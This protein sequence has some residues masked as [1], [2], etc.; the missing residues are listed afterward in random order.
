MANKSVKYILAVL[1]FIWT[2]GSASYSQTRDRRGTINDDNYNEMGMPL[3]ESERMLREMQD[4][5]GQDGD[6]TRKPPKVRKPLE[7]FYFDD[8][9]R[10]EKIF[11]WNVS[12]DN[13][14]ITRVPVDTL[15]AN[16]WIDYKFMREDVGDASLGNLGGGTIPLNYFRRP[17]P[18]NFSFLRSWYSYIMTPGKLKYYNTKTAYTRIAYSMSGQRKIEES[19][20][21]A[22]LA[23][24]ISPSSSF[25][26]E[27]NADGTKG[28]YHRQKALDRYFSAAF[29]HTG[30]RYA[31]HA[32]YIFNTADVKDNGGIV[33]DRDVTDTVFP[34]PDNVPVHLA[35]A[36]MLYKGNTFFVTQSY[37]IPLRKQ[38]EDELTIQEI[39]SIFIGQSAEYTKFRRT[40]TDSGSDDMA[41]WQNHYID[42]ATT[43][44]SINQSLL[45]LKFFAQIQPYNREGILG[46]ITGGIG[47]ELNNYYYYVPRN[48]QPG[49]GGGNRSEN[50]T[51]LYGAVNGRVSKYAAWDASLKYYMLGY[52]SQDFDIN[53]HLQLNAFMR[54]EPLTF[55]ATVRFSLRIP[56]FWAQNYF[57]NHYAWSNSFSK[58][59]LTHVSAKFTV[60]SWGLELGGDYAMTTD[61]IYYDLWSTPKQ[62]GS[63]L[64][65][66]GVYLRKDFRV[67][68]FHLNHRVLMQWSSDQTVAPVPFVSAYASYSVQ[69]NIKNVL[70]LA[71]GVDARYNTEYYGFAYNPAIGQFYN[72]RE[73]EIGGYPYLDGF[74]SGKWKRMRLLI[75]AQHFN[76][77][78]FGGQNYFMVLHRPANRMM[79]KFGMSWSFYD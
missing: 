15:L 22:I 61:K 7:S 34:Q 74:I 45:D 5:N 25:A 31:I 9:T 36:G 62:H 38:K 46:I 33:D 18:S 67:G 3:T 14:D 76:S 23:H 71:I 30:K 57:S 37:G 40:F 64:N 29:A 2:A 79:L 21:N 50:T 65:V 58:E 52:R 39:P 78:L 13:N 19:M 10:R 56:D 59:A 16:F 1:L 43:K 20:F 17:D 11:A 51:Y 12:L 73:Q 63:M 41:Y 49:Y 32:G 42:P 4:E 72:Q 8:S 66:L 60:P 53:G 6:T 70:E 44:D 47:N 26:V 24:S 55:D 69:F 27:Y 35:N 54:G 75:K 77:N 28:M 48:F 68:K